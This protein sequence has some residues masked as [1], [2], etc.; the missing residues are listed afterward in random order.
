M[1]NPRSKSETL[2][3]TCKSYLELW[4][5]EQI[6]NRKSEISSK[7]LNKGNIVE[8]NAIDFLCDQLGL[9]FQMKN[10]DYFE[11]DYV[12]G[13]PDILVYEMDLVIDVKSSWSWQTFPLFES[14]IPTKDYFYQLQ[15]YMHLTGL[16][17]AKLVYCLM[18]TP[19]YLIEREAK[20]YAWQ[21]GY[22]YDD[23]LLDEF[24]AK[25]TYNDVDAIHKIKVFDIK[26]DEDVINSII[27]RVKE[28]R[29]YIKQL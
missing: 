17:S 11:N 6:Y 22:D 23:E 9:G 3:E 21:T 8:D 28:C 19:K 14:E 10:E 5:K 29:E 7:F 27:D 4:A 24:T 26:R 25:M 12:C 1:T 13:T 20:Q 15:G 2:S 18:D 16:K